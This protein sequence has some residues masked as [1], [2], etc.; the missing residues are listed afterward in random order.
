M[1][2]GTLK[3]KNCLLKSIHI[4]SEYKGK[5]KSEIYLTWKNSDVGACSFAASPVPPETKSPASGR[6]KFD[7]WPAFDPSRID[8]Y[9]NEVE[10]RSTYEFAPPPGSLD[11]SHHI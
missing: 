8:I 4:E 2:R 1:Q 6:T 3:Q 9:N 7:P 10:T 11:V 5:I